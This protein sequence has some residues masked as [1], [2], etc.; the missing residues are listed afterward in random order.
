MGVFFM[1]N[2][3][4]QIYSATHDHSVPTGC[5]PPVRGIG[6]L[7]GL[8]PSST[9]HHSLRRKKCAGYIDFEIN[10]VRMTRVAK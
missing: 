7:A 5:P 6:G 2:H 1:K 8:S 3:E 4:T 9:A 10:Q